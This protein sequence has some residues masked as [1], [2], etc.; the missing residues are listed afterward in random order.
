MAKKTLLLFFLIGFS[1]ILFAQNLPL[2]GRVINA[3]NEPVS[4]A[5][6]SV[7]GMERSFAANVEGRFTV[8]LEAGKKYTLLVSSAGYNTKSIE[9]VE[10]KANEDNQLSIV[11]E[12]TSALA[13]V[14]VRT[15]VRKESTSA[16]LNFQR[17]NTA[18][19]SGIAADFIKRTPDKN[20]GEILK[21]VSGASIQDNKFVVVRGLGDR[22]NT[23]FLNGAQLPS[24]EPDKKAFSFD[25]IPS[26]VVDNIVI[27]KTATPDLTGEFAGGLIQVTTKDVPSRNF[28][29]LGVNIGF[30][31]ISTGKDF[32]SNERGGS[33]WTSF[34]DGRRKLPEGFPSSRQAYNRLA[35]QS[36]GLQQ[37][38]ALS[39]LFTN[40]QYREI[41][42][43]AAPIQAYNIAWGVGKRLKNDASF[44]SV[45]SVLYRKSMLKANVQR[46]L[47]QENNEALQQFEDDQNKYSANLGA[48]ANFSYVKGRHKLSFKNLFNKYYEDNYY[49][50][51][52]PNID[53]GG[54]IKLWSS[55]LN[56]RSFYTGILEG[57]HQ[58]GGKGIKAYWNAGYSYNDK[59]QPDLRTSAYFKGGIGSANPFEWD[60]DDSRRFYSSL[61]DHG[62]SAS[63]SLTIPFNLLGEKQSLKIGG[64]GLMRF[65]DFKSRIFRY[66]E[67]SGSFDDSYR[68]LPFDKIFAAS[69]IASN[70]F[71]ID[72]FTNNQDKYFAIS[73]LN[74]GYLMLDNK[75]SDKLRVI[76]GARVEYFEQFLHTRDIS[77]KRVIVNNEDWKVLPSVNFSYSLNDKN[78]IRLSASQTVSRPEFREIAPFQFFD[79]ESTFGIRGNTELKSSDIYNVD[80]RYEI[81]PGAGEA[82]T[83]GG[84]YKRFINPIE[85]RLGTE[86]VP[87][88]RNYSYANA[89]DA[90]TYGLELELRKSLRFLGGNTGILSNF[91]VFANFTYIFSQVSFNDE[92]LGKVVSADRPVQGQSPY[93]I[94]GGLQYTSVSS[95]WN[96]NILY[97]RVGSR[98]SLVGY[99]SLGFPDVYENGR[100]VIDIQVSKRIL[101]KKGELK[102]TVSDLLGQQI[103]YYENLDKSRY[104]DKKVDRVFSA[105]KPGVTLSVGFSYDF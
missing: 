99:Q 55:V 96:G 37:K 61:K 3:N 36:D 12:N 49:Y 82:I 77:A 105:Y 64:S 78:I 21:R 31:T 13:E 68:T 94:N 39:R 48:M 65:R 4:G 44:G 6:I 17:N 38:L 101:Q 102:F 15:S 23:A 67:A 91:S 73:T 87:T 47:Y 59:S 85:F 32:Y 52:G 80:A 9:E 57:S 35:Y 74:A 66:V 97:N 30:N 24:S 28:L 86:S 34:A 51:S 71:I 5:T 22:Y 72:E 81:Y 20:T 90:D 11:L 58:L 40:D 7:T 45:I 84:F 75:L 56:Q 53:R 25:V 16:L 43:A 2:N 41:K 79:Y 10:V 62:F 92:F 60:Q 69:N 63:G 54:E 33:D 83:I 42:S 70:G 29:T 88:R 8:N 14:V 27:N 98:L 76:W 1:V 100:D 19:S 103:T 89:K 93:L 18:V 104:F 95:G 26:S 46:A 50:R